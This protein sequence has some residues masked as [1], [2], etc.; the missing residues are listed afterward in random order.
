MS[1]RFFSD[2]SEFDETMQ[3]AHE[4][5]AQLS[6]LRR[7]HLWNTNAQRLEKAASL[8]SSLLA[9][10]LTTT[11]VQSVSAKQ[12]E[13]IM[14]WQATMQTLIESLQPGD[15]EDPEDESMPEYFDPAKVT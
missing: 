8:V 3:V 2:E 13:A 12:R 9:I 7:S 11:A 1:S 10:E 14:R 5:E 15:N 4:V 6:Q